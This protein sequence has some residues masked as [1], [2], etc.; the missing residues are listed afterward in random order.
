MGRHDIELAIRARDEASATINQVNANLTSLGGVSFGVLEGAMSLLM[1]RITA[2]KRAA[3]AAT[4]AAFLARGEW[5]RAASKMEELPLVKEWFKLWEAATLGALKAPETIRG[6]KKALQDRIE[7]FKNAT[8]QVRALAQK[9]RDEAADLGASEA[10]VR[11]AKARREM[12]AF[13]EEMRKSKAAPEEKE[14]AIIALRERQ[15]RAE[16]MAQLEASQKTSALMNRE[17][18]DR[19]EAAGREAAAAERFEK[20]KWDAIHEAQDRAFDATHDFRERELHRIDRYYLEQQMKWKTHAD[21]LAVLQDTYHEERAAALRRFAKEDAE[22]QARKAVEERAAA[23]QS[24]SDAEYKARAVL[25][26]AWQAAPTLSS[27]F[28]TGIGQEQQ[29]IQ[30]TKMTNQY[31]SEIAKILKEIDENTQSDSSSKELSVVLE[32]G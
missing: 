10:E 6:E 28:L 12:T 4:A 25:G 31:L 1:F 26:G 9:F 16:L 30:D 18:E 27:R 23:E 5:D 21:V 20:A 22:I 24:R 8:E 17:E 19:R 15:H 2:F 13:L 7:N 14:A 32:K 29:T 11:Q 3:E